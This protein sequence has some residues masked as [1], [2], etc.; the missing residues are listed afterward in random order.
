MTVT[1]PKGYA[2]IIT[3][4]GRGTRAGGGEPKQWRLL[5]GRPVL[6]HTLDAFAGFDRIILTLSL[7]HI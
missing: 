2:A 3:A 1:A 4:A 5:K 6:A 7:I